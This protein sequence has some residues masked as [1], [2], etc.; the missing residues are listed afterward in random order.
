MFLLLAPITPTLLMYAILF[1]IVVPFIMYDIKNPL[2]FMY[3]EK[4]QHPFFKRL[5]N[6]GRI[7]IK[8]YYFFKLFMRIL[9]LEADQTKCYFY[10]HKFKFNKEYFRLLKWINKRN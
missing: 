1:F 4:K 8:Q 3:E 5:E 10:I 2:T 7:K 6:T 9:I